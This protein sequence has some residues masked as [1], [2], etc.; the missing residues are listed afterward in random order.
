MRP[1]VHKFPKFK[2][3]D[4]LA[5]FPAKHLNYSDDCGMRLVVLIDETFKIK[6]SS[7]N[8][9]NGFFDPSFSGKLIYAETNGR[10]KGEH[11]DS[12]VC[13]SFVLI[14]LTELRKL[15]LHW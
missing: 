6:E 13:A 14:S 9:R 3:T 1:Q 15:N 4:R 12:W 8:K 11:L 5:I 2:P 7:F 10:N